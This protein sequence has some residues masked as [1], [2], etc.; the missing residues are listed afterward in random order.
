MG[1]YL[2]ADLTAWRRV[3][4]GME[5]EQGKKGE[6][7]TES[8]GRFSYSIQAIDT[9]DDV[10]G[11]SIRNGGFRCVVTELQSLQESSKA[12]NPAVGRCGLGR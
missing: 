2:L 10:L 6:C 9:L 8:V 3:K 7:N 4:G 12:A 11:L 5:G 1:W